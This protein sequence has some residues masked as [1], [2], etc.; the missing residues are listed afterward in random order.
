LW[1]KPGKG[2]KY[3]WLAERIIAFI[4]YHLAFIIAPLKEQVSIVQ[5]SDLNTFF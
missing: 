3:G 2:E 1:K 5:V 4:I